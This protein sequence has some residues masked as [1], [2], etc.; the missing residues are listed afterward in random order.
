MSFRR[1]RDLRMG[2]LVDLYL[3]DGS[4]VR[5][6]VERVTRQAVHLAEVK[7]DANG[8]YVESTHKRLIVRWANEKY[9]GVVEDVL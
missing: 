7:I 5:G 8:V 3:N 6:R 4:S 2:S 9:T 1:K